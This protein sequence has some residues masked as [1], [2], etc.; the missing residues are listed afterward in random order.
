MPV[1]KQDSLSGVL[2]GLDGVSGTK[3]YS[4]D[5]KCFISAYTFISAGVTYAVT[6]NLGATPAAV[7]VTPK[8]AAASVV[9][10]VSAG[11]ATEAI[12]SAATSAV[13]YVVGNLDGMAATVVVLA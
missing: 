9:T 10:T 4:K 12:A 3:V 6:H 13:V 11:I 2:P 1:K 7:L 8:L 5:L